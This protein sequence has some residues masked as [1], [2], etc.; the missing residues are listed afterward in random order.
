MKFLSIPDNL[1][2][3]EEAAF[4]DKVHIGTPYF[5]PYLSSRCLSMVTK[6]VGPSQPLTTDINKAFHPHTTAAHWKFSL[7]GIIPCEQ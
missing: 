6:T 1:G 5:C 7:S 3:G 4:N 2:G